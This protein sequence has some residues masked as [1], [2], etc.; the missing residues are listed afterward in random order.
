MQE[1]LR[2]ILELY[3]IYA[4]FALCT[5]EGDI[6]LLLAGALAHN[7]AFGRWSFLKVVFFGT[8]GA[9]AGDSVG[10]F[11]GRFCQSRIAEY[12]FYQVA[13]PRI[14]K[15]NNKFGPTSIF[16]SKYVYGLRSAWCIFYGVARVPLWKY[17]LLDFLSCLVWV[18]VLAGAGYFFS[19]AIS[20]L[21]GDFHQIGIALLIIV[22]VGII[23]FY[24]I[25]RFWLSKK[26]E[27]ADPERIH[28][29][30]RAAQ[31]KLHHIAEEIQEKLHLTESP[32]CD[33]KKIFS[34]RHSEAE[35]VVEKSDETHK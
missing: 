17:L 30:E 15:L 18:L 28:E 24:L 7:G 23:G 31:E 12:R 13:Q 1:F 20:G 6:T 27:E 21:I 34:A 33:A 3:G 22:A 16:I 25:E 35:T 26:V 29:I 11:L 14:E 10:Y 19:G 32:D 9:V 5:I 4:V 2:E 8:T